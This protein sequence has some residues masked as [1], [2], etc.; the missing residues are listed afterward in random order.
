MCF[1]IVCCFTCVKNTILHFKTRILLGLFILGMATSFALCIIKD[2]IE[3]D[4]YFDG[5]L[6]NEFAELALQSASINSHLHFR[7]W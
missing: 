1:V 6:S 5:G 4:Y 7:I 3:Y 2:F